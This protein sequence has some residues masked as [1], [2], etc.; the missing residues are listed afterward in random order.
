MEQHIF[1]VTEVNELVK[2]LLD[3]EPMLSGICVRGE[4]SNYKMYPSGHHY[5]SL[6]DPTGAIRCVMFKGQASRLRFR[7]ENG[8]KVVA[9]GRVTVFPRDGQY[10]L[11]CVRLTPEGAG[12][13]HVAFEQLK[14]QLYKEGLF[15]EAHKKPLP[16]FP[17]RIAIVTSSAGAAVHDMIRILRRRYP[18]AKVILLPVRVQGAEAPPEIVG[19]IRYADKWKIGDVIITGRGGGSMED[20]WAF[21]DERVA[22]AIY[23]SEIPIISAVGHEPDVTIADYVADLRA[24][25]PSNGAELAV[26]DQEAL[27]QNLDALNASMAAALNRQL[28]L[29]GQRLDALSASPALRS[30]TAYLDRKSKDL[31]LLQNRL[32]SAQERT[33]A[34][35]NARFISL[36][37]KLDAMSPLKVLSRGYAIAHTQ[38]GALLRSVKQTAPNDTI[39]VSVSDGKITA[40]VLNAKET[41]HESAE[42][43]V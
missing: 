35:D 14:E 17:E 11:Y 2:L 22:Y 16:R 21:N 33:V 30:P 42:S 27:L 24:A 34:G 18:L 32:V 39:T 6:K 15:D 1:S 10:Q 4:I 38:E 13:L 5:F 20:L 29:A 26:P 43:D 40:S 8:M 31:Q 36:V 41:E 37:A 12:D 28:K 25:T 3:N 23:E 9:F 7:P 19:A